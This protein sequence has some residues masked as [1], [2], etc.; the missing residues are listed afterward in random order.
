[1]TAVTVL[2]APEPTAANAPVPLLGRSGD[3]GE[4]ARMLVLSAAVTVAYVL[5]ASAWFDTPTTA[6]E[7]WAL[8][9]SLACVLLVRTENVL[10]MPVGIVACALLG[11]FYLQIDLVGQGW[12]QLAFY[13]PVQVAGWW[14]WC[15]GGERGGEL[16]IVRTTWPGRLVTVAAWA[17][18]WL[19]AWLLFGALYGPTPYAVWDTSIVAA[20]IVAQ[21][22]MSWKRAEHWL[23]WLI[24]VNV[25]S[26]LLYVTTGAW[27]FAF[28]Y[29][30]Y[31]TNAWFGWRRWQAG[32][33]APAAGGVVAGAAGG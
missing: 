25:S 15:R 26:I 30:V 21:T 32:I 18:L 27:A 5:V 28:L 2:A 17:A 19:G 24:P 31:L 11:V 7:F 16:H 13:I 1:M 6:L 22:L 23:V 12:L 4:A 9:P 29:V 20:S 33:A 10:S 8:I 14:A 3:A